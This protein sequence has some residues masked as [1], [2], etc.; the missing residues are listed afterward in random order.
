M[1]EL[2]N[3]LNTKDFESGSSVHNNVV[4]INDEF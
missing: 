3:G 1:N 2:M 4:E